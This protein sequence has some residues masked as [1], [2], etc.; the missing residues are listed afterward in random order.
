LGYRIDPLVRQDLFL[1]FKTRAVV[2]NTNHMKIIILFISAIIL[3][4]SCDSVENSPKKEKTNS[5]E[6]INQDSTLTPEKEI[7]CKC[8]NGIGSTTKS[9]PTKTFNFSNGKAISICGYQ[10]ENQIEYENNFQISEFDIFDCES[11]LSYVTYGAIEQFQIEEYEDTL[12][13]YQLNGLP[14]GENWSWND[15]KIAKQII[16]LTNDSININDLKPYYKKTGYDLKTTEEFL[17]QITSDTVLNL[18][19]E[20]VI[21]RLK[22]LALEGNTKAQKLLYN[23]DTEFDVTID[24]AVAETWKDSKATVEWIIKK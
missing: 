20:T 11:G 2:G 7:A 12:I 24:G 8:F 4:L 17:N 9:Q 16:S 15:V 22:F 23:F 3:L 5:I 1:K 19:W 21:I 10:D 14:N 13:L 6:T 18:E